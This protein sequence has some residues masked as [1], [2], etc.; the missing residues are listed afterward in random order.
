MTF[1]KSFEG[2]GV[3]SICHPL[4]EIWKK[5]HTQ[6][7]CDRKSWKP[8]H[9]S[10][11]WFCFTYQFEHIFFNIGIFTSQFYEEHLATSTDSTGTSEEAEDNVEI[12]QEFTPTTA[13]MTMNQQLDSTTDSTMSNNAM[14]MPII[15]NVVSLSE[16]SWMYW[17]ECIP[18]FWNNFSRLILHCSYLWMIDR[19][20]AHRN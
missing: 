4:V 12:V 1:E 19:R 11:V 14:Q 9:F 13:S 18:S 5:G 17:S 20:W 2:G 6:G 3:V 7:L 15:A 10:L 16:T 8:Q